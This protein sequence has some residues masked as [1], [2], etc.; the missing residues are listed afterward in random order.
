MQDQNSR[1]RRQGEDEKRVQQ[2][3]CG[4]YLIELVCDGLESHLNRCAGV[5]GTPVT[6]ESCRPASDDSNDDVGI[7]IFF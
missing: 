4:I 5:D 6:P 3:V 1:R 2:R 7:Y